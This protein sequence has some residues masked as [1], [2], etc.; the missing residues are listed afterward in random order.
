MFWPLEGCKN[1]VES[2]YFVFIYC[3]L[4]ASTWT[5]AIEAK[6][7][8]SSRVAHCLRREHSPRFSAKIVPLRRSCAKVCALNVNR[9][10]SICDQK[11]KKKN[12]GRRKR[13]VAVGG[14]YV[15]LKEGCSRRADKRVLFQLGA[16]RRCAPW[17]YFCLFP[18]RNRGITMAWLPW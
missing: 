7:V 14:G 4:A 8:D 18:H 16:S 2:S 13:T 9:L 1:L 10:R 11:K 6:P 12:W 5:V 15:A 3:P 17:V